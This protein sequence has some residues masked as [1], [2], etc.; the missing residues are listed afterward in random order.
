MI[1]C[2]G[3]YEIKTGGGMLKVLEMGFSE[4]D[5]GKSL[6]FIFGDGDEVASDI[7]ALDRSA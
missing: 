7:N 6:K 3:K 5:I 1:G 2:G 4:S